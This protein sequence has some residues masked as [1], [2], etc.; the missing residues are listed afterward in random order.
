MEAAVGATP[1]RHVWDYGSGPYALEPLTLP[2]WRPDA[3]PPRP[4][5]ARRPAPSM[6]FRS[7]CADLAGLARGA[8]PA[9]GVVGD[10]SADTVYWFR[11]I[12]GHQV[13]FI[14]WRL[15][16]RALAGLPAAGAQR[17]WTLAAVRDYV[18]AYS[19]LLLYCGSCP[20]AVYRRVIRPSMYRQ[21]PAFSGAW[22][23]DYTAVRPLLRGRWS[24]GA[25]TLAV[26]RLRREL[27]L[28]RDVHRAVAASLVPEG[29]SLLEAAAGTGP[30][31]RVRELGLIYD[32]FFQTTRSSVPA[33]AV[34]AQLLRRLYAIGL[35]YAQHGRRLTGVGVDGTDGALS[36]DVRACAD[37]L[38]PALARV[39]EHAV[40]SGTD[41]QEVARR[42]DL[43]P[44]DPARE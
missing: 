28:N 25:D 19:A 30:L 39:A 24:P 31:P 9:P 12:T 42:R 44:W 18:R 37:E 15:V 3:H 10:P 16:G 43:R 17:E 2:V 21:H 41:D 14:V 32:E 5:P 20:P 1:R 29:P 26:R 35:D 27:D 33:D 36:P 4:A 34:T 8:V 13:S 22:A 6:R 11:W 7:V 23:P 38:L 40:T